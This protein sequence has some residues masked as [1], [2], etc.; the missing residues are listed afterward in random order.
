MALGFQGRGQTSKKESE[1]PSCPLSSPKRC[2]ERD[3]EKS[4]KAKF[5]ISSVAFVKRFKSQP[6]NLL[7]PSSCKNK[8]KK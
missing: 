4:A 2:P 8:H 1:C 7:P 3:S 5:F 6:Q